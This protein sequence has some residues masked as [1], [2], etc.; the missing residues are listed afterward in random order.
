MQLHM[1]LEAQSSTKV[2]KLRSP[3]RGIA[4]LYF[5]ALIL[6]CGLFGCSLMDKPPDPPD[7]LIQKVS[8]QRVYYANYDQVWRAAHTVIKYPIAAEN[9]DTGILETEFIKVLDGWLSPDIQKPPSSGM[10][11][12]LVMTFAKGKIEGRESTRV[13]LEKRIEKQKDFFSDPDQIE[14]D[15]LEEKVI[16]YRI[17]RELVINE[18]LKKAAQSPTN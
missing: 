10:R 16:F 7:K 12:K 13:T 8:R 18:A 4:G 1:F 9:Q 3:I 5:L 2:F 14:S 17:E 15:G 11:Y 6:A